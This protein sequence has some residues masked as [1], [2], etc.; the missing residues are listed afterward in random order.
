[1]SLKKTR[2]EYAKLKLDLI[3]FKKVKVGTGVDDTMDIS[4]PLS[5]LEMQRLPFSKIRGKNRKRE[6]NTMQRLDEFLKRMRSKDVHED[7]ENWMNNKL[8]FQID[9]ERAYGLQKAHDMVTSSVQMNKQQSQDV[10]KPQPPPED[11]YKK[12]SSAINIDEIV[13]RMNKEPQHQQQ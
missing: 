11:Y 6:Q 5:M 7:E 13:Q 2:E 12:P 4:K 10:P 1:M 9:S 8:K 3:K